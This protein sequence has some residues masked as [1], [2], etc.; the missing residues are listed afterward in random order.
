[1]LR[2]TNGV[3]TINVTDG[4]YEEYYQYCGFEVVGS[5][6]RPETREEVNTSPAP[7]SEHFEDSPQSKTDEDD[8]YDD[9]D[10]ELED[11]DLSQIPL[12]EMT[13]DQLKQYADELG[14]DYSG[15]KYKKDLRELI[16]DNLT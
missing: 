16:K 2:I 13:V 14:I 15:I 1:M 12:S 3:I 4:A 10:E 11:E 5:P 9:E 7:D 8:S 6:E